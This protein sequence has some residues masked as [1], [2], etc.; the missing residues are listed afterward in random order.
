MGDP[1]LYLSEA[2]EGAFELTHGSSCIIGWNSG[3]LDIFI[4]PYIAQLMGCVIGGI[5]YGLKVV[6]CFKHF[7]ASHYH[8]DA[9]LLTRI[10]HM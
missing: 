3:M 10:E 9:R 6:F 7:T 4:P 2:A 8:H 5:H 1:V